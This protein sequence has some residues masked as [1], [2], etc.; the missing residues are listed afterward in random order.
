MNY[1]ETEALIETGML[2]ECEIIPFIK[3]FPNKDL[4]MVTDYAVYLGKVQGEKLMLIDAEPESQFIQEVRIFSKSEETKIT[5]VK[6]DFIWRTRA[7]QSKKNDSV[8]TI[9]YVDETHK[10]WGTVKD[11]QNGWTYLKEVRGTQ[12]A[13]PYE[14]YKNGQQ[15]GLVF[16]KYIEFQDWDLASGQPFSYQITDERL[17]KYVNW[18]EA[19]NNGE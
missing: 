8:P 17:V 2:A 15:I 11:V 10:L 18:L 4:Y 16:R 5:R 19:V 14:R 3:T 6:D 12:I 13:V 1:V 7:D 9:Y